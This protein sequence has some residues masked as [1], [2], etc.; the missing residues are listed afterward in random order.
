MDTLPTNMREWSHF[1]IEMPLD[2]H[3]KGPATI[4]EDAVIVKYAV[5]DQLCTGYSLFN[6]LGEAVNHAMKLTLEE[7]AKP[8]MYYNT[9]H[10]YK[11]NMKEIGLC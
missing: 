11:E 9:G 6:N 10:T 7:L 3:N 2:K 8:T 1:P 4:G 5:W